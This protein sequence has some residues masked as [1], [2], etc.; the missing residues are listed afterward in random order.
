MTA[1]SRGGTAGRGEYLYFIA[2]AAQRH[3]IP[4]DFLYEAIYDWGEKALGRA[5]EGTPTPEDLRVLFTEAAN[6]VWENE[7]ETTEDEIRVHMHH[8][9]FLAG[10]V[11]YT[12]DPA[13][14]H[15][16]CRIAME[17]DRAMFCVP[18]YEYELTETVLDGCERC[19]MVARRVNGGSAK[20]DPPARCAETTH[21]PPQHEIG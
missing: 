1:L 14:L 20:Q 18:G 8:C 5:W 19:T 2:K 7:I 12:D 15:E 16:L 4:L 11:R 17:A 21:Q 10:W 6:R 3:G 13:L 9:P